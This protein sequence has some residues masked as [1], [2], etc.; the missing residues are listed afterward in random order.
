MADPTDSKEVDVLLVVSKD[1][2]SDRLASGGGR[3]VVASRSRV[4]SS[5]ADDGQLEEL[6]RN[7]E[8]R[9]HI[10]QHIR[11]DEVSASAIID[12]KDPAEEI[13]QGEENI[14]HNLKGLLSDAFGVLGFPSRVLLLTP[15]QT[16]KR[17]RGIRGRI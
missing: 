9:Q 12:D 5:P 3:Y 16:S 14:V 6:A 4:L 10:R 1:V 2:V 13:E 15:H 11:Q 17:H 8:T 7:K